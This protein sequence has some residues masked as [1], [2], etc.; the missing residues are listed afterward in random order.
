[1][2]LDVDILTFLRISYLLAAS[3]VL[4][5]VLIPPLGS[6][7]VAY[8][9]RKTSP[10]SSAEREKEATAKGKQRQSPVQQALD[11]AATIQ[12]PHSWFTSFYVLSVVLSTVW[13]V[14]ILG[15]GFLFRIV[16]DAV[17]GSS[18]DP[19][20]SMTVEQVKLT[21][22]LMLLQGCRRLF[23]CLAFYKPSE[24]RMWVGHWLL[25]LGFYSA[26]SVSVWVEGSS[27]LGRHDFRFLTE[28]AVPAPSLRSFLCVLGFLMASGVQHD[29]HTYLSSLKSPPSSTSGSTSQVS[30]QTDTYRI[31]THPAFNRIL[32][33][34]YFCECLIY[35][36]LTIAAAPRG[37]WIN[38]TLGCAL[39]FVAVNLGVTARGTR[40]WY[41]RRFG[42]ASIEGK[43][44]MIPFIY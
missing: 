41:R 2:Y 20:N 24:S 36:F 21:W 18:A 28:V 4:L 35:L 10:P 31:P 32:T 43:Y 34:H 30:S 13:A 25:G 3:L 19:D 17:S 26:M 44:N 16:A 14:Q 33:P 23:E 8:G 5:L 42:G 40:E 37:Y 1:M 38:R 7:F 27:S 29:C 15:K 39:V 12:V 22:I 11:A 9:A 6:R